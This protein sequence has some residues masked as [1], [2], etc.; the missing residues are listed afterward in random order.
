[1]HH[2]MYM[3]LKVAVL[4]D[5]AA[6]LSELLWSSYN[7]RDISMTSNYI[8]SRKEQLTNTEHKLGLPQ[9]NI[10]T[11]VSWR[12]IVIPK[13]SNYILILIAHDVRDNKQS[14]TFKAV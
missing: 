11:A 13:T 7:S 9:L 10:I 5:R 3:Y 2:D 4:S 12:I 14:C 8:C 6:E 1:M